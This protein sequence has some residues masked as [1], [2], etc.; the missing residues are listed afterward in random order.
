MQGCKAKS[1]GVLSPL[2][3]EIKKLKILAWKKIEKQQLNHMFIKSRPVLIMMKF[4]FKDR[5]SCQS[6][7]YSQNYI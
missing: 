6:Y 1:E 4:D 3:D 5:I 7:K 2:Y